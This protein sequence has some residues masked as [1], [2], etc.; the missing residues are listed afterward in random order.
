LLRLFHVPTAKGSNHKIHKS[1]ESSNTVF[2]WFVFFLVK[3]EFSPW[4][5]STKHHGAIA[6]PVSAIVSARI[7]SVARRFHVRPSPLALI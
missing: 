7:T 2:V 3:N 5:P 4:S 6:D 1:H